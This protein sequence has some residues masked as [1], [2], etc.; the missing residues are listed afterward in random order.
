NIN[1]TLIFAVEVY[2][3][4]MEAY[5]R[6]LER[7][8]EEGK[9]IDRIASVASFFV[10]RVDTK[11]DQ[12]L[13]NLLKSEQDPKKQEHIKSL[14]GTAAINNSKLAYQEYLKVF[15]TDRFKKLKDKG[16]RV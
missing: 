14:L 3:H 7:R 8:L 2:K 4:V 13:Q 9:P 15:E 11:A 6:A 1:I 12:A 10:S 16:A 5:L